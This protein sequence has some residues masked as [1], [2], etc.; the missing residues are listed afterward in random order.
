[1]GCSKKTKLLLF[2]TSVLIMLASLFAINKYI[3]QKKN[4]NKLI[5]I[6]SLSQK[7]MDE[8][9]EKVS[10]IKTEEE[11]DNILI[12]T[13][14]EKLEDT[15]GAVSVIEAPNHQY[16]LQY[17]SAKDKN[18]AYN[19]F[20]KNEKII[21]VD[22]NDVVMTSDVEYNSWG[23][24]KMGLDTAT[25]Q[26]NAG[27]AKSITVAIIDT[28]CDVDLINKYYPGKISETYN[29]LNKSTTKMTD[30]NGHGTH[31]A[32]T[33]AEGT[34]S[35][36]KIIPVKVSE[37]RTQR[38]TDVISGI[39]YVVYNNKADVINLSLGLYYYNTSLYNAIEA[40][41]Q[42]NIITIAAAGND[43]TA[44]SFYPAS[45]DNTISIASVD[46]TLNKSWFSNYGENIDF[47]APGES[48]KSTLGKNMEIAIENGNNDGD[49]D[50]EVIS[51]TSMATPHAVAAV[52]ILKSYN[53]NLTT[54]N[55]VDLLRNYALQDLGTI[56][57]DAYYGYGFI[58]FN[59]DSFCNNPSVDECESHGVFKKNAESSITRFEIQYPI[60]TTYNY[61]TPNNLRGSQV[62]F[63]YSNG[64]TSTAFL[65]DLSRVEITGYDAYASGEQTI[66]VK[67]HDLETSFKFTN[68]T[69]WTS[70][71]TYSSLGNNKV[72]ITGFKDFNTNAQTKVL[73]IPEIIDGYEVVEIAAGTSG[74]IFASAAKDSYEEI[75][76]PRTLSLI[77][78]DETF[79]SFP[80]VQKIT[81]LSSQLYIDGDYVFS[82]NESLVEVTGTIYPSGISTFLDDYSLQEVS[83]D[84]TL[85]L[86]PA[87]TFMNCASL[88][89]MVLPASLQ[90]IDGYAFAQSGIVYIDIPDNVEVVY[91]YAFANS[92][93]L[94]YIS[95]PS[96]LKLIGKYSFELIPITDVSLP[97][98]LETI[99]EGAFAGTLL[100]DIYIPKNVT[101]I[102]N[103]AFAYNYIESI[104]VDEN[105]RVFDSRN[106][107][108]AIINSGTDTLIF[109]SMSTI[110]PSTVKHI[111]DYA[112]YSVANI[113]K[114]YIPEGVLS[115][116]AE[117]FAESTLEKVYVP[118]SVTT[119][120]DNAFIGVDDKYIVIW[121]NIMA[122]ART[123]AYN[124]LLPY[125]T[126]D[127]P[128]VVAKVSL[129][130]NAFDTFK[131][132][133]HLYYDRAGYNGSTYKEYAL[134]QGRQEIVSKDLIEVS[135][136]DGR[137][138]FEAGDT[139]ITVKF[140]TKYGETIEKT[141]DVTVA[142]LTPSYVVP[143]GLV[144]R[145]GQ[146][147]SDIS[148]PEGFEWMNPNE[149]LQE[150][151]EF[152]YKAKYVPKDTKNYET[153]ENIDITINVAEGKT[154]ITPNIEISDKIYDGTIQIPLES[155]SISNLNSED[156]TIEEVTTSDV[157]AGKATATIVIK[158]TD[159]KFENVTFE[160]GKQSK[161]F[162]VDYNILPQK[163]TKPSLKVSEY[164]YTGQMQTATLN[165]FKEDIMSIIGN[166]RT[167]AG[168]Q[169]IIIS[170]KSTNYIWE[171]DTRDNV[172]LKFI[173][174]KAELTVDYVAL[175]KE[176]SY[177][178]NMHTIDLIITTPNILVK[179]MD[180]D[181]EYTLDEIPKYKTGGSYTIKFKLYLD[182]NHTEIYDEAVLKIL[183]GNIINNTKD[184]EGIYDGKNHTISLDINLEN[185]NVKY[186]TDNINYNLTELPKYSNVGE[187]TVYYKISSLGYADYY[188]S[189][190]I[191]I[192]GIKNFG[193]G[194]TL[195]NNMLIITNNNFTNLVNGINIYASTS[196]IK[197]L[198]LEGKATNNGLIKTGDKLS[199]TINNSHLLEYQLVYLG[200]VNG[201]GQIDIIDY[202][203]IMKD[204]MKNSKL[205]GIY[206]EA[207]DVNRNGV[208]D[209]IDYI[210]IMK[211][212]MEEKQ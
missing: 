90:V 190:K 162:L 212:I 58:K 145:A 174:D 63:Y 51:G 173:I 188:G 198:D 4:D 126:V 153:I 19:R 84:N 137:D 166:T 187:Y 157:N 47:A 80:F 160:D 208:I 127:D 42:A 31:I 81:N 203:R 202:I 28:G 75:V 168:E 44:S 9:F 186:S 56:G 140:T 92:P 41:N 112:F 7:F 164:Q 103:Y 175:D 154:K 88:V 78:G 158:L 21:S 39:N 113:N 184:F 179:Y 143:T 159:A 171:D 30:T 102:G 86:L 146:K 69:S 12:V 181:G 43:N 6:S 155:I 91:D 35:N 110:V 27:G 83:L 180:S 193:L 96:K 205:L 121:T 24:E 176:V 209:I 104:I 129:N 115:I 54:E 37:S 170:L 57:K 72:K 1:M 207:A 125:E 167:D 204:I 136:Q 107:S 147:L 196:N 131:A 40:A 74:S 13:S 123:Y 141:F 45:Y 93:N 32:G 71:W 109:G 130:F 117:A 70:G 95:M 201:N 101:A 33:I 61:G 79:A 100:T 17:A 99:G 8:Y 23:I 122:F 132:D 36:V 134:I 16:F 87:G 169:D 177:D 206:Y 52:A 185:Y 156:Y 82:D 5:N 59:E 34:P 89:E 60:R 15:Y 53:K 29:V 114:L 178:G 64:A 108:N 135:Y 10:E 144:A 106:D 3:F 118:S 139:K 199:I 67:W 76:L 77:T 138:H 194:V 183:G 151:G 48:I 119:I 149:E 46:S 189:N 50:H 55:V 73:Y 20:K 211:I 148:L 124:N 98:T 182:N 210:R 49:D 152:A 195:K 2:I 133:M 200:D 38:I 150:S 191:K 65:G 192:Y 97:D 105:N 18:N 172:I 116:G 111:G 26:T 165:N 163:I 94:N 128:Y 68:P 142:K 66:T 161:E 25:K 22:Q 14:I 120:G 11:K 62:K 85:T 197:H